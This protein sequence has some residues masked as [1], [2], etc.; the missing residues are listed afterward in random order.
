MEKGCWIKGKIESMNVYYELNPKFCDYFTKEELEIVVN[1][2]T[3]L[4]ED[5]ILF[6]NDDYFIEL[7]ADIKA[8]LDIF[9]EN[10][11]INEVVNLSKEE[12]MEIFIKEGEDEKIQ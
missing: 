12:L 9:V 10:K 2:C 4:S 1:N 5:V 8:E 11:N 6:S 3:F 7:S